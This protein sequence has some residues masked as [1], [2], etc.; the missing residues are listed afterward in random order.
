MDVE[1]MQGELFS[2]SEFRET[3]KIKPDDETAA[4]RKFREIER[5][6]GL[7]RFSPAGDFYLAR[8]SPD[9][10]LL[11]ELAGHFTSRFGS[12]SW[13]II[14][15]KRSLVL[16]RRP[17]AEACILPFEDLSAVRALEAS[18]SSKN[19]DP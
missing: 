5:L 1:K 4:Y 14:D 15:E 9:T 18:V 19:A 3:E 10:Y 11:P 13:V 16:V 8:C 2:F 6:M 7:L 17:P 12:V